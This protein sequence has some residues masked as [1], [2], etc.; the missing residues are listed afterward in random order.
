MIII[1]SANEQDTDWLLAEL[2][3]FSD[4]VGFKKPLYGEDEEY[5][6]GTLQKVIQ[7]QVVFIA[8]DGEVT[9]GFIMGILMPHLFNKG[10]LVLS[11]LFWWVKPEHRGSR[12]GVA[13][14]RAFIAYGKEK[15]DWITMA[16]ETGSPVNSEA[17]LKRG[18]KHFETNFVLEVE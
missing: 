11:E 7:N 5:T 13:L 15:A 9:Q 2:K 6:R 10:L 18:F 14:L 4:S 12:A 8:E 3:K 16:L 17:L 1:R